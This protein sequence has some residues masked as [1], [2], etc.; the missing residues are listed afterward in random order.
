MMSPANMAS[1]F[2]STP[3]ARAQCLQPVEDG[4][5]DRAFRIVEQE[6][7]ERQAVARKPLRIGSEG[8]ADID[9]VGVPDGGFQLFDERVH[10]RVPCVGR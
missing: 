10:R 4:V 3:A 1:R 7:A 8:R 5:V 9:G 2:F 6:V